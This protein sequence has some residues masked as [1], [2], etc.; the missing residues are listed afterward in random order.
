[1]V[2]TALNRSVYEAWADRQP[3]EGRPTY[4]EWA[5]EKI[6]KLVPL[7]RW[8]EPGDIAAMAVFLASPRAWNVTGQTIN[9]DGGYVMHW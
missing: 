3:A 1:M 9:V 2:P 7:G 5:D 6:R 8:Q 4:E